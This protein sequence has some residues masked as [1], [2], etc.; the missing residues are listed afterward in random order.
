MMSSLN[1]LGSDRSPRAASRPLFPSSSASSRR[2]FD[3]FERMIRL[4]F[5]LHLG[6][7]LFEIL[8]RN[9]VRKI[10]IVI[11][12]VLHRR[13]RSELCFRPDF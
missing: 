8:G 9:P 6:L 10:D 4:N 3:P 7:D 5:V 2:N 12:A 13:A 11:K 1:L